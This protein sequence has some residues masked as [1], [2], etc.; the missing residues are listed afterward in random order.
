MT[1]AVR[2]ARLLFRTSWKPILAWP[3]VLVA[4]LAATG[5]SLIDQYATAG[6]RL[7]YIDAVGGFVVTR[8]FSGRSYDLD[9][10]GG[11]LANEMGIFSLTLFPLVG[12]HLAIRFTR[13]IEDSGQLELVSA[14]RVGRRAPLVV[15]LAATVLTAL[16]LVT[17]GTAA[18][19]ALGY[20][21]GGSLAY[22]GGLGAIM[23]GF[24]VVGLLV[25]QLS[26]TSGMAY[27]IG[28]SIWL[29]LYL[30]RAVVDMRGVDAPW[31]S[32]QTWLAE[33]RP[34]A[35]EPT[36]WPWIAYAAFFVVLAGAAFV[37]QGRRDLGAGVIAPR[38]GRSTAPAWLGGPAT[39][40]LR[41][42][43]RS[44]LAWIAGSG[45][46]AFVLGLLAHELSAA[47]AKTGASGALAQ[48]G[49]VV[50]GMTSQLVQ[51]NAL[52]VCAMAVQLSMAF[53]KEERSTRTAVVLS[54]R[55]SRWRWWNSAVVVIVGWSALALVSTGSATGLGL[56]LGLEDRAQYGRALTAT[57]QLGPAVLVVIAVALLLIALSSRLAAAAWMLVAWTA[58]V[59]LRG[60]TLRMAD[61]ARDLSPLEWLGKVP[62]KPWN[63]NGALSL[64]LIAVAAVAISAVLF[65]RRS[66]VA[67]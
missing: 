36:L 15:G 12:I 34:F 2:Y 7:R 27:A 19:V 48:S 18:L 55:F 49:G 35:A 31:M 39:L 50:D 26:M 45:L 63:T 6:G 47:Q 65:R 54:T 59:A 24:A 1:G 32:P 33:I 42:T 38:P 62:V 43:R 9:A 67:S 46:F 52:F 30:A 14:G 57:A 28:L 23:L 17:L 10:V 51:F 13:A 44:G 60:E 53:A 11:I 3:V 16:V 66:L 20:P 61:W 29:V 5:S 40:L 4:L 41:L 25:G 22:L 37:V 56:W 8:S 64:V 21:F 58:V